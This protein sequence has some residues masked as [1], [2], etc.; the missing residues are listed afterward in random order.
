VKAKHA[1][2]ALVVAA[3]GIA[4]AVKL[5]FSRATADELGWILAPTA[6]LTSALLQRDFVRIPDAGYLSDELSILVTPACAGVNFLI[7][8]YA[9][10]AI[11]FGRRLGSFAAKASWLAASAALAFAV[12]VAVNGVRIALSVHVSH[13]A[14]HGLGLSFH[15]AHRLLGVATYLGALIALVIACEVAFGCF[16]PR[17]DDDARRRQKTPG[18]RTLALAL[19]VYVVVTLL[20]PLVRGAARSPEY[21]DHAATVGGAVAV[22]AVVT[23]VIFAFVTRIQTPLRGRRFRAQSSVTHS[24][25]S[26]DGGTGGRSAG[27]ET[28]SMEMTSGHAIGGLGLRSSGFSG[29]LRGG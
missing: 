8:A 18:A 9:V 3:L 12:A 29:V 10:L 14:M 7:V 24:F 5:H 23:F 20:V 6:W 13:L 17:A 22:G 28:G 16:M 27:A 26:T 15:E 19:A 4:I 2:A 11:G 21:W 1:D 25:S